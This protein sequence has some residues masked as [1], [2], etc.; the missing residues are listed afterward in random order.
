M[1]ELPYRVD[2]DRRLPIVDLGGLEAAAKA[3]D[4]AALGRLVAA[5]D[6]ACREFGV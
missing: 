2:P 4:A 6:A 5:I 3:Q 1:S